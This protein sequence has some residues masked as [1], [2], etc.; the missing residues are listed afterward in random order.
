M[1]KKLFGAA[2]SRMVVPLAAALAG[3]GLSANALTVMGFAVTVGAAGLVAWGYL[4]AGGVMLLAG[5]AFD[6]LDGAVARLSGQISRRGAFL[7][8]TLDRLSDTAVFVG[9]MVFFSGGT[10]LGLATGGRVTALI[11]Q[12]AH[13]W[14]IRLAFAAML[15]GL[16]V[17]YV[18]ARAEG[19]GFTCTVGI[20]ERPERIILVAA[21]LLLNQMDAAL[22]V[23]AA[24]SAVT[25]V[26]RFVHV[27]RQAGPA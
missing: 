12:D 7:D 4:L 11:V 15:L 25:L 8:S 22:A 21:G 19:L 24:A 27:W 17:S 20:A 26:Q 6:M 1:L 16:M 2:A 10:L 9:L 18:R 14:G 23:L 13:R 5:A 3:A